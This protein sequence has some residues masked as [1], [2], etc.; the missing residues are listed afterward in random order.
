V[1]PVYLLEEDEIAGGVDDG[2]RHLCF[3]APAITA[4]ASCFAC[5]RLI[6]VPC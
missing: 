1:G 4:S 5:S 3:F 2:D 6:G